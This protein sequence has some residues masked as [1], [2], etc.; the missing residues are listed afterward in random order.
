[1]FCLHKSVSAVIASFFIDV[2]PFLMR[3]LI[4]HQRIQIIKV[5]DR[6]TQT[7]LCGFAVAAHEPL[8]FFSDEHI[9]ERFSFLV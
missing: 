9:F 2:V 3:K 6:P 8:K 4:L 5:I 1:M 7:T